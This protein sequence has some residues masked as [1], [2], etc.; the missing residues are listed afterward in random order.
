MC[1]DER[2]HQKGEI[3]TSVFNQRA[4]RAISVRGGS[5]W[6]GTESDMSDRYRGHVSCGL[7]KG[8]EA[9]CLPAEPTLHPRIKEN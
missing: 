3:R 9:G 5:G 6:S 2:S 8:A 1:Y 4:V 7:S